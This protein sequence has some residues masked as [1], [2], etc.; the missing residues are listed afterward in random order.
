MKKLRDGGIIQ[1]TRYLIAKLVPVRNKNGDIMLCVDFRN[2]NKAS[3]K[4]NY[5]LPNIKHMLQLVTGF[6]LLSTLD[7]FSSY[8]QVMVK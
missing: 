6:K 7:G 2:L 8:N 5:P 3:M 1:P 4:E